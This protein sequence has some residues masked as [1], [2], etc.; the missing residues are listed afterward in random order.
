[1]K[2]TDSR[3]LTSFFTAVVMLLTGASVI[4]QGDGYWQAVERIR[5]EGFNR[6]RVMDFA[7]Y[8]ADVIGPRISG[9]TNMRESQEWAR[10][11]MEQI[12]LSNVAI[13]PWGEHGVN[14]DVEYV[15]MHMLEPDYQPLIG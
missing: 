1:M 14:W 10:D 12:G 13:E 7:W 3:F 5:N 6:S 11:T 4:S 2:R 8:L 15:S 9:S